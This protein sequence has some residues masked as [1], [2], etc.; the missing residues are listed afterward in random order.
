M[1]E[2][3]DKQKKF[4]DGLISKM[5]LEEKAGQLNQLAP[6]SLGGFTIDEEEQQK[7][8]KAGRIT[9]DDIER[10]KNARESFKE[11][12]QWVR[13]GKIGSFLG[14]YDRSD[15]EHLQRI[16]VEQSRLKIPLIFG[17]DVIHGH[18]V[19]GP[20]PLA[21]ACSFDDGLWE[22]NAALAAKARGMAVVSMTGEKAAAL[23][24]VSDVVIKVPE[25]ETYKIQELHL[26]V[27][28]YIC[29]V[30]EEKFFG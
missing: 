25:T 15:I 4:I 13:E 30:L 17:F 3:N 11:Q 8:L 5:T 26:P 19:V 18:R 23:D 29:A 7:L 21:E 1:K 2:L 12:E 20:I 9:E 14:L 24:K 16:A 6:S 27:Y 10:A 22:Q 28:H